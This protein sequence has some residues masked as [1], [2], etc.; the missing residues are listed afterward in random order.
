MLADLKAEKLQASMVSTESKEDPLDKREEYKK[1]Y[2]HI[3]PQYRDFIDVFA[4]GDAKKLLPHIPYNITIEMEDEKVPNIGKL[5]NM[6]EG[7]LKALKDYIDKM[8]GK[9]FI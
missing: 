8:L 2:K 1:L 3:P 5:Y 4:P 9:G 6:S 7:E